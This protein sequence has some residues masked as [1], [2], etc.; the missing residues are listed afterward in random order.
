MLSKDKE[1]L[2]HKWGLSKSTDSLNVV[3]H[4]GEVRSL[5]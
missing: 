3:G 4:T 2:E 5:F 1:K